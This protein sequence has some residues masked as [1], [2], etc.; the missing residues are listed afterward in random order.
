M[1]SDARGKSTHKHAQKGISSQL[2]LVVNNLPALI[3]FICDEMVICSP[4]FL[5]TK[6]LRVCAFSDCAGFVDVRDILM[7][8]LQGNRMSETKKRCLSVSGKKSELV[9]LPLPPASL[10]SVIP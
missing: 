6:W 1:L 7:S 9:P 8:F 5:H 10:L 2:P 3:G 4:I